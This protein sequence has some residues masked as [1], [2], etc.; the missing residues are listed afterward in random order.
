LPYIEQHAAARGQKENSMTICTKLFAAALLATGAMMTVPAN[1][2]PLSAPMGLSNSVSSPIEAV[3]WRRGGYRRGGRGWGPG[4]GIGA[5][6]AAGAIIGS[7]LAAPYYYGPRYVEP[8]YAYAPGYVAA[9]PGGDA[10]AYCEQRFRSYDPAS[11]T[12]LGYDGVH[13]PCP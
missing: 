6:L 7:A 9:A 4:I 3:Q 8:G 1:A 5:G 11:G 13:H 10:V 12:Y 2:A